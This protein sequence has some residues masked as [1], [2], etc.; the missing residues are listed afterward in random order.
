MNV[1]GTYFRWL[2]GVAV[3]LT[4]AAAATPASAAWDYLNNGT[5]KIGVDTARGAGIGYFAKVSDGRNM[6][7]N[8]DTGC[9]CA[10]VLLRG[11]PGWAVE[12]TGLAVES[13]S[14][15]LCRGQCERA[16]G[17]QQ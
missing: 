9:F 3:L 6:L 16:A 8:Y 2:L 4:E 17:L 7:N 15:R 13:G 12:W 1:D 5:V 10:T 14:G 11:F